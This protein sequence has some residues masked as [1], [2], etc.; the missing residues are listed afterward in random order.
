MTAQQPEKYVKLN[1]SIFE[2]FADDASGSDD[3]DDTCE[4]WE[5]HEA[6]HNDVTS[7]ERSKERLFEEEIELKWEKGGS[8]LV[9]YTG[10]LENFVEFLKI[11]I[12]VVNEF[13][14]DVYVNYTNSCSYYGT[15]CPIVSI[16]D[17]PFWQEEE[18][19]FEEKLA[20]LYWYDI[21]DLAASQP[22]FYENY[23][24]HFGELVK[25]LENEDYGIDE[26]DNHCLACGFIAYNADWIYGFKDEGEFDCDGR[27][28]DELEQIVGEMIYRNA[29]L[30]LDQLLQEQD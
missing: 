26:V 5:R 1:T 3:D 20:D 10:L 24:L 4:E 22:G 27:D 25:T 23:E 17:A 21:W 19:D 15:N 12:L 18:G 30:A 2:L 13:C 14:A 16:L 7:Q 6:L 11:A 28:V 29:Q 8:G 9:F